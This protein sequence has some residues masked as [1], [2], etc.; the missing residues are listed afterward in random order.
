M[1]EVVRLYEGHVLCDSYTKDTCKK[2][3]CI[4]ASPHIDNS[5]C[6]VTLGC[7]YHKKCKC[8]P[9]VKEWEE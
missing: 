5:G 7:S 9:I 4:H 6:T 3:Y 8:K 1:S 2:K